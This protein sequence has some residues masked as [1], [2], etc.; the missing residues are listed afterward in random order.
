MSRNG[1]GSNCIEIIKPFAEKV[2]EFPDVEIQLIGGVGSTALA[3]PELQIN[4]SARTISAPEDLYLPQFRDDGTRRDLDVLVLST[5]KGEIQE[6]EEFAKQVVGEELEIS[7]FGLKKVDQLKKQKESPFGVSAMKTFLSD[8]YL[9]AKDGDQA[10]AYKAL[11]P[12]EVPF[13]VSAL[14]TWNLQVGDVALP[15][16]HPGM[17]IANYY[18]RSISGLRPKDADKVSAMAG[19]IFDKS[20]L[21]FM[22]LVEGDGAPFLGLAGALH[23]I[24]EPAKGG[25]QLDIGG[26]ITLTPGNYKELINNPAFSMAS[27]DVA[28]ATLTIARAKARALHA[29]EKQ[30][31]LVTMWQSGIEQKAGFFI[32]NN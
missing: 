32:K 13:N 23:T 28:G 12:F 24:R 18:T 25:Q 5:D 29:L 21:V 1:A 26:A 10:K 20:P 19:N 15:V 2:A 6:V 3:H 9:T 7:V 8:R 17:S 16:P 30:A 11:F 4:T 31:K 22:W 14:E 27:S